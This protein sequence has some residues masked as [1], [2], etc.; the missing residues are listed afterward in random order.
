[1]KR[2][3][4]LLSI[5]L[6]SACTQPAATV[7]YR[8]A[9]DFGRSGS[10]A[11]YSTAM[12]APVS[13]VSSQNSYVGAQPV[14][15]A[16][17]AKENEIS[18]SSIGVSELEPAAGNPAPASTVIASSPTSTVQP[19]GSPKSASTEAQV[20]H[21]DSDLEDVKQVAAA[22]V[23]A[24]TD[25]PRDGA[26]FATGKAPAK[27]AGATKYIWPVGSKEVASSKDGIN[28]AAKEGEPVWAA[29]DGE[30][31]YA[32]DKM[33]GY[34]NMVLVKHAGGKTTTYAHMARTS[35]DKYD[36]VKQGDIIGYVGKTGNVKKPQ[37]Y[38]S[39]K[40]GSKTV[41]PQKYLDRNVAGL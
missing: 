17:Y 29:A 40:D 30:V 27:A 28:I 31:V 18:A 38:F 14:Y 24:W 13:S 39:M 11:A 33:K 15:N 1:M 36:R 19:F 34:G 2:S 21:Y 10:G 25:K 41:D 9:H 37:L 26:T 8:G 32:D 23:N 3:V 16:S 20:D 22:P 5:L 7:E 35:V 4:S 12:A 6:A